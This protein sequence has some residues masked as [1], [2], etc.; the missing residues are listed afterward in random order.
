MLRVTGLCLLACLS[1]ATVAR[2]QSGFELRR[3]RSD[4]DSLGYPVRTPAGQRLFY[5]QDVLGAHAGEAVPNDLLTDAS[6]PDPTPVD[7]LAPV[8][9]A[10]PSG[11]LAFSE[12]WHSL[13]I[14]TAIGT[15]GLAVADLDGD[16][17][18]EIVTAGGGAWFVLARSPSTSSY[19]PRIGRVAY[20]NGLDFVDL[21]RSGG[22]QRVVVTHDDGS[23]ELVDPLTGTVTASAKPATQA[24]VQTVLA[25]ADND[26]QVDLAALTQS[27]ILLLDPVTLATR[28]TFANPGNP[29]SYATNQ[30]QI[31]NVD[32]D[33][34]NEIVL[35][36]GAVL[37]ITG[38]TVKS[39]GTVS[40]SVFTGYVP[41]V[42]FDVDGD[43]RQEVVTAGGWNSIQIYDV[44]LG[45]IEW[46]I[47]TPYDYRPVTFADVTG[48]GRP[49]LLWGDGQWGSI[50]AVD[51]A[52]HNELWSIP[53]P[54]H[55][56]TRIA[57]GDTD[58]DGA[59][60]VVWGAG[61][62]SSGEDRLHVASV[63]TRAIEWSSSEA[64]GP[65]RALTTGD[66][67]GDG[68]PEIVA[69]STESRSGYDDG[70]GFAWDG[71]TLER[72]WRS[73][74]GLFQSYAWTGIW[75][76]AVG[77]VDGDGKPEI[78]VGTDWLYD[79]AMYVFDGATKVRER[80]TKYD[81][82]S[83]L[84]HVVVD[85]L[86]SDGHAEVVT[87]NGIEHTGSPGVFVTATDGATGAVKWKTAALAPVF[88][89]ATSLEVAELDG[90]GA[91]DVV[92]VAAG[93]LWIVNG[94]THAARP[95]AA[96][97]YTVAATAD[98]DGDGKSSIWA[99]TSAGGLFEID[100]VSLAAT[101]RGD[102]CTGAVTAL[103]AF[104]TGPL[105]GTLVF[106]C[107]RQVGVYGIYEGTVLWRSDSLT[108]ALARN[109]NLAVLEV[110]NRARI[111]VG[112]G[113]GVRVF[114]GYGTRN[115]DIDGDG[116]PNYA[117]DCPEVANAD[118]KD[119]DGDH[120]GDAC[121]DAQDS[122]GDEWADA[123]DDCPG[124]A[125]PDQA[126]RDGD[127]LGDACDRYPDNPDNER[128]RCD[129]AIANEATLTAELQVCEAR[130]AFVDADGDGEYDRTDL[131][132][133][134][135]PGEP[136]DSAG[137][138]RDQFCAASSSGRG[139]GWV[140]RCLRLDWRNDEPD[141]FLPGDCTVR[142]APKG[143][144]H[145]VACVARQE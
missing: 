100:P 106:T 42:L 63:T 92:A 132:P 44:A 98:L 21:I 65:Y 95:S 23:L 55:G 82:G 31:G 91:R 77:D 101:P 16:G 105:P 74:S 12:I 113:A 118:Q 90:D 97:N 29:P 6:A 3:V 114:E 78:V 134:T 2:G 115:L 33:P 71:V 133:G 60:E 40:S 127:P 14:G 67:D 62:T 24:I 66:I 94:A 81:S 69:F 30:M 61:Y 112:D 85:D 130:P 108:P 88:S 41:F 17:T 104:S 135:P 129:E 5:G 13:E 125:N 45:A 111:V 59:L 54:D 9:V 8:M 99:A 119:T 144:A 46:T 68:V 122:D 110:G 50:H 48:D 57:V 18:A 138:S 19:E 96:T 124:L 32:G 49:E 26:G 123:L 87:L 79:G 36:S 143:A 43:G 35:S 7:P 64:D 103:A 126:N 28:R 89:S 53:N 52:T 83:P 80:V 109:D 34:A 4:R 86:D 131:C 38:A 76:T 39:D 25:D 20:P 73:D 107:D 142:P 120:V 51:L 84:D 128:A 27:Q 93:K 1:A 47:T 102:L 37:E 75:D 56:V 139:L 141:A 11:T 116:V 117:D 121:N 140:V 72:K 58:G 136:V 15:T 137:C 22:A 145:S 10:E 70:I